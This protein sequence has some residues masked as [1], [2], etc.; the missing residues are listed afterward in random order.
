MM[1]R[2]YQW[3]KSRSAKFMIELL[4]SSFIELCKRGHHVVP[5]DMR[6]DAVEIGFTL[7]ADLATLL[8]ACYDVGNE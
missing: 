6:H 3:A 4:R 7:G 1:L 5:C 2:S 8:Y